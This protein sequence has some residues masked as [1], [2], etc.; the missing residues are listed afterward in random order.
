MGIAPASP[1]A[2]PDQSVGL[3]ARQ[4]LWRP[5]YRRWRHRGHRGRR[6]P[7]LRYSRA[8]A[9][10]PAIGV[11]AEAHPRPVCRCRPRWPATSRSSDMR[12]T[13]PRLPWP[14]RSPA[15]VIARASHRPEGRSRFA[16][17]SA[18]GG[19]Q[20]RRQRLSTHRRISGG[21]RIERAIGIAW[22]RS[23]DYR[24]SN[25]REA[26]IRSSASSWPPL[27]QA[28]VL[29]RPR[30]NVALIV[31]GET[32]ARPRWEQMMSEVAVE[33]LSRFGPACAR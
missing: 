24:D 13:A 32:P 15:L 16:G 10:V 18:E 19:A 12:R 31:G 1:H 20:T 17:R 8:G 28:I 2:P 5:A 9:F 22:K 4:P 29:Q 30:P 26:V 25:R 23:P 11:E 7:L 6:V 14:C 33:A 3:P 27:V 21:R